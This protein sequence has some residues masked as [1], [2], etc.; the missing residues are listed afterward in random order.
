MI[1]W[2]ANFTIVKTLS[3]TNDIR[4]AVMDDSTCSNKICMCDEAVQSDP[5]ILVTDLDTNPTST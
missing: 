1:L 2:R 5:T 4:R 3:H